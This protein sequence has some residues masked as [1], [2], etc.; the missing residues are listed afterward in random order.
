MDMSFAPCR[1]SQVLGRTIWNQSHDGRNENDIDEN[2]DDESL[3]RCS[4][5]GV[6]N[7]IHER[8]QKCV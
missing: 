4:F 7:G 3:E 1:P 6:D 2:E 5:Y 8:A